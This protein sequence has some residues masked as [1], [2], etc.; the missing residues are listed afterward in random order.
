[1]STLTWITEKELEGVIANKGDEFRC[2]KNMK[3]SYGSEKMR[4]GSGQLGENERQ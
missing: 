3:M 1:M 4:H 2:K